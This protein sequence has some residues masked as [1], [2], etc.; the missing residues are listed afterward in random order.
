M[1]LMGYNKAPIMNNQNINNLGIVNYEIFPIIHQLEKVKEKERFDI[2][3]F[4]TCGGGCGTSN[5]S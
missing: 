4:R 1:S 2:F 3:A 5:C